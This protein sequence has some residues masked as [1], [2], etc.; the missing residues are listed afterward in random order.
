MEP[1]LTP[2]TAMSPLQYKH[3]CGGHYF[4][5]GESN[6]PERITQVLDIGPEFVEFITWVSPIR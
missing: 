3:C 5:I 6:L 2:W 1:L 4:R